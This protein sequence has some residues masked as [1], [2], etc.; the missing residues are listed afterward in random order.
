MDQGDVGDCMYLIYQGDCG[1]Y[2]FNE[3]TSLS[4]ESSHN[5]VALVGANTVVGES[6]VTDQFE[7][8]IRSATIVAHTDVVTLK[9]TKNNYQKILKQHQDDEKM[10]RLRYL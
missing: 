5:A 8:G 3:K 1:V 9:L 2:V 4:P 6:A 10:A 7:E